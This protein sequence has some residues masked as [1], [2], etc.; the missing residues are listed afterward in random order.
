MAALWMGGA[1]R[2]AALMHP[3]DQIAAERACRAAVRTVPG[4]VMSV[5][6]PQLM[7]RMHHEGPHEVVPASG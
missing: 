2:M 5:L 1:L 6:G 3:G 7:H 4:C